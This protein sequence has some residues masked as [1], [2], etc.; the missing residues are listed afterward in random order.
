MAALSLLTWNLGYAGL[1]KDAEFKADGGKRY[2]VADPEG[3]RRWA[4]TIADFLA[5]RSEDVL[6]LQEVARA[7]WVNHRI[8]LWRM[9]VGALA[10]QAHRYAH[11]FRI[12]LPFGFSSETACAVFYR[13]SLEASCELSRLPGRALPFLRQFPLLILR[14]DHGGAPYSVID[15]HLAAFD[16]QARLRAQQL[17]RLFAIAQQEQRNGRLV[18]IGGD[19]NFELV[20]PPHAHTTDPKHMAWLHPFPEGALPAEWQIAADPRTPT[21]RSNDKPYKAGENY[22]GIID[23]FILS[24]ELRIA[25][26]EALDLSFEASDHNPV[27]IEIEPA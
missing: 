24:P 18:A 4:K 7:S 26:I 14:F 11:E 13:R 23:G 9:L 5:S 25:K 22:R 1:G 6:L 10:G 27:R 16:P 21:F 3:P 19:F 15:C 8:D 2:R 20:P 12:P 17:M